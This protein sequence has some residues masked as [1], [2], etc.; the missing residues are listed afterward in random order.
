MSVEVGLMITGAALL[1]LVGF[2][3]PVLIKVWRAVRDVSV[4]LEALNER[5]PAILKNLE[6]ISG[7]I[8]ASTTAINQ[9]VQKYA[10]TAG[11]VHAAIDHVATGIQWLSPVVVRM[12][13]LRKLTELAAL[14]KGIR[15]F[16][17]T[18]AG[19]R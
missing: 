18:L 2:C 4:T 7:N 13:M 14:A 10:D 9:E 17:D 19:K 15:V 8:N 11:K 16:V 5:L 1:V 3:I 12:P 6:E